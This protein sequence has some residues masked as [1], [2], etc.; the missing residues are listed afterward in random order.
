MKKLSLYFMIVSLLATAGSHS[1]SYASVTS[2][3]Y[4]SCTV[5]SFGGYTLKAYITDVVR[6]AGQHNIGYIVVDGACNEPYPWILSVY[7]DNRKYQGAAGTIH[8]EKVLQGFIREGGGNIPLMFQTP[9]TGDKW[10]YVPDIN[11]PNY[12]SYYAIRDLGPGAVIPAN[13]TRQQVVL[14]IDP[15][16]AAWV[17]GPDGILFT[18]DDNLYGDTSLPT[19]FKIMLAVQVPENV[20]M[21]P[22]SPVGEYKTRLI[23]EIV[24][25]P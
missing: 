20:P 5:K 18:D 16:N 23:F 9:N 1:G 21:G 7:T 25:E 8:A 6:E 14:G 2:E 11:D 10:V 12:T 24:T 19:P 13:T 3:V 17:A 22:K 4:I 15:R